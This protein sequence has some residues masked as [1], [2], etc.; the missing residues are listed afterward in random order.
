MSIQDTLPKS[1]L[2]LR[3]RTEINGQ[4]EDIELPLRL[5]LVGDFSGDSPDRGTFEERSIL[6]FD[7]KNLNSIMQKMKI[8][9]KVTDSEENIH[10]IPIENVDSFLPG[11]VIKSISAMDDMVKAKNLLNSLLSSINN[12]NKFRQTLA[13]LLEEPEALDKLKQLMAPGYEK[14]A[15]LPLTVTNAASAG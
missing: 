3:Y 15:T 2:T 14:N 7:G 4:P 12:S 1:R 5:L 10:T 6:S 8:R 9:L 11:N 13:T